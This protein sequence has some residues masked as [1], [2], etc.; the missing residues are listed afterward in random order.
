M[1]MIKNVLISTIIL[2]CALGIFYWWRM[3]QQEPVA[4]EQSIVLINVL[5]KEQYDDCHI[6][7]SHHVDLAQLDSFMRSTAKNATIIVYCSN[8]LCSSS[9]YVAG[10]LRVA[11]FKKVFV[12]SGGMAE[13]FQHKLPVE[14]PCKAMY[15]HKKIDAPLE[16]DS[17]NEGYITMEEL[18]TRMKFNGGDEEKINE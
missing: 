11:G 10:R 1:N 2:L 15:L 16:K 4:K 3:K 13:W 17:A 6:Q 12:Y 8:Y 9:D 18:A 5:E 14:G 7:G